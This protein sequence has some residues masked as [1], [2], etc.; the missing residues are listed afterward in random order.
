MPTAE[1]LIRADYVHRGVIWSPPNGRKLL[2]VP[3]HRSNY[4]MPS[5]RRYRGERQHVGIVVHTPEEPADDNEVTP[6]WFQNPKANASTDAYSDNDGDL[7]AMVPSIATAWAQ[8][9][10]R[11]SWFTIKTGSD[12]KKVKVWHKPT[13]RFVAAGKDWPFWYPRDGKGKVLSYNQ[14]FDSIEVEGYARSMDKTFKIDGPQGDTLC[15]WVGWKMWVNNWEDLERI[16]SHEHLC[17]WK[18]DP[19]SFVENLFPRIHSEAIR[20]RNDF[21][22]RAQR[23]A[24]EAQVANPHT[25]AQDNDRLDGMEQN[26]SDLQTRMTNNE[27]FI[28]EVRSAWTKQG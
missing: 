9:T 3:A 27:N 7:Y 13:D 22:V 5:E 26:I 14:I 17:T 21:E 11:D 12:G 10:Q 1:D 24:N 25:P 6:Q 2:I 19:G 8:G 28:S 23:L 18:T 16:L 15:S 20:Y 4:S